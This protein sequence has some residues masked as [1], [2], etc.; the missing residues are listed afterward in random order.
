MK[1][2]SIFTLLVFTFSL[3][4]PIP[5]SG[6]SEV[7]DSTDSYATTNQ[8]IIHL[9]SARSLADLAEGE[10]PVADPAL[11]DPA[12]FTAQ[13]ESWS[14]A[15][16][17][18]LSYD[19]T[20]G[21][22]SQVLRLPQ[23]LPV[24][25][26]Q[27]I[28]N[29]LMQDPAVEYAEPDILLYPADRDQGQAA[30]SDRAVQNLIEDGTAS[31][32]GPVNQIVLRYKPVAGDQA[33]LAEAPAREQEM[34]RLSSEAGVAL[35]Y[36]RPMSGDAHV[37]SLPD[38][39]PAADAQQI[40]QR[41]IQDGAVEYAEPDWILHIMDDPQPVA[42]DPAASP[43]DPYY[44]DA[45]QWSLAAPETS[46]Y[47]INLGSA[48]NITHGASDLV[49]AVVDTGILFDHP[50][51]TGR[52]LPG[53]DMVSDAPTANDGDG[54]D[55]DPSDPGDWCGY[56]AKSSS[57]HGSH[58]AGI[59]GANSNNGVGISGINWNS[60]IL[61]VRVLGKCGGASS[62]IADGI[63]WAAGVSVPGVP[64][65]PNPAKVIN[66]S[67][68]GTGYC[69]DIYQNAVDD[70][71]SAGAVVVV[72]AGNS[73][74]QVAF[75]RPANCQGVVS[76]AAST[77]NGN[78]A[79]YSN[80]GGGVTIA[81]P[82]GDGSK[83]SPDGI[84]S[85]VNSGLTS[86]DSAGYTYKFY[87]GTSMAAPHVAGVVSLMLSV[88]PSLT[89]RQVADLLQR[90]ATA[91]PKGSQC[92][93]GNCGGGLLNAGGAVQAAMNAITSP[94]ADESPR[95]PDDKYYLPPYNYQWNLQPPDLTDGSVYYAYLY[96]TFGANL[97]EAWGMNMASGSENMVVA[98]VD[99]G[100][101]FDHPDLAG[102]ILP[103][104]DM[105]SYYGQSN[106]SGGSYLNVSNDGDGRDADASDPGDWWTSGECGDSTSSNSSWHGSHVAGIIAAQ[107]DN[108]QGIAGVNWKA[109][110]LPVRA[111]GKC[112][113]FLSDV[114]DSV[115]YA[116]G[117]SVPGA[118]GAPVHT[119]N[120]AR[121]IN[122]S[123]GAAWTPCTATMQNAVSLA[124]TAGALVVAAAGN[125]GYEFNRTYNIRGV[126]SVFTS[127]PANCSGVIAVGASDSYGDKAYFSN[128]GSTLKISAPG[129]SIYSTVNSSSTYPSS[130][131]YGYGT[132]SGT[133]QAAPHVSGILS[134][135]LS[136]PR[137][138]GLSPLTQAEALAVLMQSSTPFTTQEADNSNP[139]DCSG[140]Y[141]GAGIANAGKAVRMARYYR[142]NNPLWLPQIMP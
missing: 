40:A 98:V 87:K 76:V 45:T 137:W 13:V 84:Y 142:F 1:L 110:I 43:N 66:L 128:Y 103:G 33:L 85:T 3:F 108:A 113:G 117:Y 16:G 140:Y 55:A 74:S 78:Q 39:T 130:T 136:A 60:K 88:N 58:V 100:I 109:K 94:L 123:L 120:P 93:Y 21:L 82:G 89:S 52:I 48:W 86:P 56:P 73:A 30:A 102:K 9:R 69:T 67:L 99:T 57:W 132:M 18:E 71:I 32:P 8:I 27:R 42:G 79:Y 12:G 46:H 129:T 111:L 133:S 91:F 4:S 68:G 141:C 41:L 17:V 61:P 20:T 115:L 2:R 11:A 105:I 118:G 35:N 44:L 10:S 125:T 112:G 19:H 34:S 63:R 62:D 75:T 5:A 36:V 95:E 6:Q 80:T 38:W 77:R 116:A 139:S 114:A 138:N 50:D 49:V 124:K 126:S 64:A 135:I 7:A 29:A 24:D 92:N 81:A 106:G 122:M 51:L 54:Q 134:L 90:S 131:G 53:Y 121:V 96:R 72:A 15:A 25:E 47:G 59:I 22:G 14:R 104:Y 127:T 23:R 107:S 97:P 101:L 65:N 119:S 31:D 83:D 37:L 70:A 28:A 26:V